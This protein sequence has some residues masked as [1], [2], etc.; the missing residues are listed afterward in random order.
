MIPCIVLGDFN[1]L[2]NTKGI[3]LISDKMNDL[4]DKYSI[5][6]TRPI[7]DDR[8]DKENLVCDYIFVNNKVKVNDFKVLNNNSSD[9]LPLLLDFEI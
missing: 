9:H 3:Q 7:F 5:K 2:L 1:L 8:L 6:T 4:I